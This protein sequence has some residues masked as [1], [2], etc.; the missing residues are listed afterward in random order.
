M[1]T[2]KERRKKHLEIRDKS[3]GRVHCDETCHGL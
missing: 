1:K 2:I 3:N